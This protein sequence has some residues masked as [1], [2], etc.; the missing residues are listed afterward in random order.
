MHFFRR[1][2]NFC[3]GRPN[4]QLSDIETGDQKNKVD[5]FLG[6]DQFTE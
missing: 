6:D 4:P 1:L 3:L 5:F 2:M